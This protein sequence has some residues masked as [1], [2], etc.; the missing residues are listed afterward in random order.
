MLNSFFE[1]VTLLKYPL[2]G[3]FIAFTF[4]SCYWERIFNALNLKR[5]QNIQRVHK[6]EVS[7]L[8]GLFIYIFIASIAL[9]G[10]IQEKLIASIMISAIPFMLIGVKEDIFHNTS[11]RFR[12]I[13]MVISCL[14]FFYLNPIDFPVIDFPYLGNLILLQPIGIVFFTFSILVVMNGMNLIDGMN[15]LFGLTAILQLLSLASISF[16]YGDSELVFLTM[17]FIAPLIVFLCFNFPFGKVFG[18]DTGAYF[19]GFVNAI[20]TIYIFGKYNQLLSWLAVL[21]LFYPSFELLFSFI[22]KISKDS[23]PL[24]PDN[25]HLHT[26]IFNLLRNKSNNTKLSNLMTTLILF[27]LTSIPVVLILYFF[28]EIGI[29]TVN[30]SLF[31]LS[32]GYIYL[33]QK[34]K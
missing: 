27:P 17:I 23:S 19:Y 3:L 10:F 8:G 6:N 20:L 5:Y 15:G 16:F 26:L 22:R 24:A 30:I 34:I 32:I 14:I 12:L 29:S 11:P 33:Y 7:R 31:S 2:L 4:L 25:Q 28:P 18:G 1:I 9:L 21:I 13:T